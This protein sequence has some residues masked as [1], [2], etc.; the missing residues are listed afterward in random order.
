M[1]RIYSSISSVDAHFRAVAVG[2]FDGVHAG[3]RQLLRRVVEV[4]KEKGWRPAILTFHPHPTAVVAPERAPKLLTTIEERLQVVRKEGIE[5]AFVL[6]F[7]SQFA[8]LTPQQFAA[9]VLEN[10]LVARRVFVGQNFRFGAKQAGDVNLLMQLGKRNGFDVEIVQSVFVRG[11]MVSSTEV[12]RVLTEG[13]VSLAC[14]LLERPYAISGDIVPGHGI[15][16][17]Q[18]VPTL[19]LE[20]KAEVIPADGVYVTRTTDLR[21]GRYWPSI[22]NIG[23]RPTF[24]GDRRTIETFLLLPLEGDTPKLIRLEFLKR[25]R[26]ER[27]FDSP[28]ALKAQ[29]FKDVKRAQMYFR[30]SPLTK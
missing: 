30:R 1:F 16:A 17:K 19:N 4:A 13:N 8:S 22:T 12:R 10:G 7:D 2:N 28:E 29:I 9:E 27:K 5:E 3:H 20:T 23:M 11:R 14:R 18:T 21:A 15:G 25:V 24:N 6:P 26:E